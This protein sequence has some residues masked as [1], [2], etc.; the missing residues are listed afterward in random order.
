MTN[1]IWIVTSIL[2]ATIVAFVLDRFRLDVVAFVSLLALL[3]SGILTPSEATAGFSNSLVLMI[4]GLFV[5]GGAVMESG[6]AHLVGSWLS[7]LG[8][9]S[10]TRLTVTVMLVT[11]L[12]SALI[13]STGTVA[14]ILPVVLNLCRRAKISPSKLLI[15][16][17]FAASLGGMLTLIGTPPNLAV[18]QEL[19]DAGLAPFHFFSF[20]PAGLLMLCVG[21]V[22]MCTVGTRLLP[23]QTKESEDSNKTG[24][25]LCYV[26]RPELIHSYGVD[27]EIS[28][29]TIP[30]SS[31]FAGC[32][33]S[34]IGLR[35][36]FH[37]SALAISKWGSRGP[38]VYRCNADTVLELGDTVFLKS[39]RDEAVTDLIRN[40]YIELVST[41]S[42]L[43]QE[44]SLAELI[45][46]PRSEF[47]GQ[48]VRDVGFYRRYGA[49]VLALNCGNQPVQT[50][51]SDT[52]L[53]PGDT[54]LI[55]A[56]SS[57]LER[58]RKSRRNVLLVSVQEDQRES[59][60]TPSAGWII[61]I[62]LGMLV[63]MSSGVVA[64]VTAVLVAAALSVIAGAFRGSNAYQ[65]IHWESIVM[66]ASIL[67]MATALEKTGAIDLLTDSIVESPGLTNPSMLLLLLFAITSLLSQ[68]IS[69]TAT[70]VLIAPLALDLA[71]R[72]DVSPYPLLMGVALAASTSFSTPVASPI[73]ALVTGAGGYHFV[74]FL[75]VG[76]PLQLLI[77][78]ATLVIVPILFP[79]AS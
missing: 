9:S 65:S 8:G 19:R 16:L 47:K 30:R 28:E 23:Q 63:A 20:A 21:I 59:T 3:I 29:V 57:A 33:L 17:A 67:P 22:F 60:L 34:D 58:L 45:I 51:T 10:T 72:L 6:V 31:T 43:P 25:E 56:N 36:K 78:A 44:V 38:V 53:N 40:G 70:S 13:S 79:F 66:I 77:L 54:L 18:N 64:N 68:A 32:S 7:R 11:A 49:M 42:S 35:T 55:A 15:P 50:G 37:V 2:A 69:N 1:D 12:T 71:Q 27:G 26:S 4:A 24:Q 74:D 61:A 5:V 48:T 46:P 75:K 41:P 76:V 62:M 14:V 39:S 52:P 73:N